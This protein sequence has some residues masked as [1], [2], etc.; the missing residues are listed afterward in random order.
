MTCAWGSAGC[1]SSTD[2]NSTSPSES[3]SDGA[4]GSD[5]LTGSGGAPTAT[6]GAPAGAGGNATGGGEQN[7]GNGGAAVGTGGAPAGDCNSVIL[8]KNGLLLHLDASSLTEQTVTSWPNLGSVGGAFTP[9]SAPTLVSDALMGLPAVHFDGQQNLTSSVPING[10]TDFTLAIVAAT[11][12]LQKPGAEWCQMGE[13]SLDITENGCSG[14]YNLPIQWK[15]TGDW[16]YAYLGPMQEQVSF[17]FGPGGKTYYHDLANVKH[18]PNVGWLRPSSIHDTPT[19]TIAVKTETRLRLYVEGELVY[20]EEIP[21]GTGPIKNVGD[22]VE[23]GSGRRPDLRWIGNIAEVTA[24]SR[25][26]DPTQVAELD[27]YFACKYFPLRV[28][29]NP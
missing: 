9:G 28:A 18:D 15:D 7:S 13:F 19:T 8:D 26:L 5:G 11:T 10:L 20:D 3:E 17:R 21:G 29:N 14:T 2:D 23:L 12:A 16:G 25:A 1:G 22:E 27:G 6:G 24:Y 4:G